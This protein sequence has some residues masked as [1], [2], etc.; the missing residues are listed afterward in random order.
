MPDGS[1]ANPADAGASG[2]LF[3]TEAPAGLQMDPLLMTPE[4]MHIPL[5]QVQQAQE[6]ARTDAQ[7]SVQTQQLLADMKHSLAQLPD[8]GWASPGTDFP[9]R[10]GLMKG[11]NTY[12]QVLGLNPLFSEKEIAA[13]ENLNKLTTRLGFDLSRMLGSGE[14]ASVIESGIAA[15]PGGANSK[16]GAAVIIA[17]LEA[18]NRRRIDYYNFLQNWAGKYASVSGADEYFNAV[19][20]PEL[21]ALSAFV[22]TE[23]M[24]FL[25]ENPSAA[26]AFNE[27]YGGGKDVAK[28]VLGER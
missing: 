7:A 6:V 19:N 2:E 9:E 8:E 15:V 23:A 4:T 20:P 21:Y 16:D 12:A 25:R 11:A 17:S 3:S 27:K 14:A 24:E 13:G 28:Y 5:A 1:T 10:I 26:T 22:P 18:A